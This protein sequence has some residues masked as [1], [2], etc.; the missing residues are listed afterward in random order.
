MDHPYAEFQGVQGIFLFSLSPL[1][2][3]FFLSK[4][5]RSTQLAGEGPSQQTTRGSLSFADGELYAVAEGGPPG[6]GG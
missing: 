2:L 3:P 1:F 6:G 4:A 5:K